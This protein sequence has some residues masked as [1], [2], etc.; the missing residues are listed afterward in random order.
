[1]M[2]CLRVDL[3]VREIFFYINDPAELVTKENVNVSK[4]NR[5][6]PERVLRYVFGERLGQELSDLLIRPIHANESA[7]VL[8]DWEKDVFHCLR[9][10]KTI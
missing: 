4:L 8:P 2:T 3:L 10:A 5:R 9:L 7:K 1:M 6:T